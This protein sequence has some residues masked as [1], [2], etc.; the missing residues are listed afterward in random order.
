MNIIIMI[1]LISFLILVH[2]LGHLLTA[3]ALGFKVTRFGFVCLWALRCLR[4]KS[5][6]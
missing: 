1:L 5:K 2:E 3:L 6:I 4:Q